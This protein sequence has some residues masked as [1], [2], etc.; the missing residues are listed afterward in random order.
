M[1][2]TLPRSRIFPYISTVVAVAVALGLSLLLGDIIERTPFLLFWPVVVISGWYGGR[3]AGLLA[4]ALTILVVTYFIQA[5]QGNSALDSNSLLATGIFLLVAILVSW[6]SSARRNAEDE[7]QQARDWLSVTLTS[8]GDAVIATDTDGKITFINPITSALTGWEQQEAVGKPINEVF[9]I[10][11]EQTRQA[12]ENPVARVLMEGTIVGL[13]N[14]TVL[15]S[16]DGTERPIDDSGA[17]IRDREGNIIGAVLVFHDVTARKQ[18]EQKQAELAA[19]VQSS[20]DAI[21]SKDLNGIILNWNPGAERIYGYRAEEVIGKPISILVPPDQPDEIPRILERLKRGEHINHYETQRVTK[22]G[23]RLDIFLSVS[24]IKDASGRVVAAA[25]IARD[26]TE[27]KRAEALIRESEKRFRTMADTVPG[28]VW[29]AGPDGSIDYANKYWYD[30]SGLTEAQTAGLEWA[31]ILHPDDQERTLNAWTN[32]AQTGAPY[33]LEARNRRAD[34]QWRWLLN[35]AM[36]MKDDL[37]RITGWV[38]TSMDITD[39]KEAH[40]TLRKSETQFRLLLESAPEA[41]IISNQDGQI[42]LVNAQAERTFGYSREEMLGKPIEMLMP[43]HFRI[44]HIVH[45]ADYIGAPSGRLMGAG[46]DLTGRRKD[47]SEFPIEVG[48]NLAETVEGPQVVSFVTDITTRKLA[49]AALRESEERY[50]T[51]FEDSP[52]ALSEQDYSKVKAHIEQLRGQG[53]G[54]LNAYLDVHPEEIAV[55]LSKVQLTDANKA[56][57]AL[58]KANSK[59]DLLTTP[60]QVVPE[61]AMPMQRVILLAIAE[62]RTR[63]DA[64]LLNQTLTGKEI[65]IALSWSVVAGFEDTYGKVLVSMTDITPRKQAEER[66]RASQQQFSAIFDNTLDAILVTDDEAR[67]VDA[68]QVACELLGIPSDKLIGMRV[69]DFADPALEPEEFERIW[70]AFLAEGTQQEWEYPIYRADGTVRIVEYSAKAHFLPHR[71]VSFLRDITKRKLAE[72]R[73]QI[74]HQLTAAISGA[75]TP[76]Q[77][78][79]VVVGQGV[80]TL[81]G[82]LAVVCRLD[83]AQLEI[84][85]T[86]GVPEHVYERYRNLTLDFHVPITDAMRS[87]QPVWIETL[88][89]YITAYPHLKDSLQ[90]TGSKAVAAI[91]LLVHGQTL[92]GIGI[93]FPHNRTFSEEER[94]F[95]LALAQQ[96]AQALERARLYQSEQSAREAAEARAARIARLQAVTAALSEALTMDEIAR[97]VVHEGQAALKAATGA[98]NLLVDDDTFEVVYTTS[99]RLAES[100]RERWRRF[101]ADLSFPVSDAVRT[102]QPLW[103]ETDEERNARYPAILPLSEIYPGA[104]AIVPLLVGEEAIGAVSWTFDKNQRLSEEER[105]FMMALGLLCAQALERARL[106]E[107]EKLKAVLEERQRIARDL[108]DAVSQT[109]FA[110]NMMAQSLPRLW[111]RKPHTIPGRLEELARLTQGAASEMRVLLLELRPTVLLESKLSELLGQLVQ[112]ARARSRQLAI[113]IT[114]EGAPALPPDVHLAFYRVAQETLNNIIKHSGASQVVV[115]FASDQGRAELRISDN[116]KG[117]SVQET[118]S[119]FGLEM[120]RERAQ[121]IGA[122]LEMTSQAGQGSEV[123]LVWEAERSTDVV[124]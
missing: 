88:D 92:G 39:L 124:R 63:L 40:E 3:Q 47:G 53:V 17:P 75:L 6:F 54:D 98:L 30:F 79:D 64:E 31:S 76:E 65:W 38:G 73:A 72:R 45:R 108:H 62:G 123:A 55:C 16:K 86:S 95:I 110:A 84:L 24:P 9:R 15:I 33:E 94:S 116:G 119:G 32:A 67:Y 22:D 49:E 70:T 43:E 13:A 96:C 83:G 34:G 18:A 69:T 58:Y 20:D 7:A 82:S 5:P 78:A 74:L 27:R 101:P 122:T 2:T 115:H 41:I 103:L 112:I 120:M 10:V 93:S 21:I 29:T 23:K 56:D 90:A 77:V 11:N 87:Q 19:I 109:L 89:A 113:T 51:L 111:E 66:L 114:I 60:K 42:I 100:E 50:R 117:F 71:H 61:A 68:N 26:I 121:E 102:R 4:T 14:H 25:K 1:A 48:L 8:I 35:R 118:A 81:G 59:E 80:A 44:G 106:I 85:N 36:P 91:P 104:W 107:Q 12:V 97:V 28:C 46:R 52:I 99:S 105:A 57:V 37:N